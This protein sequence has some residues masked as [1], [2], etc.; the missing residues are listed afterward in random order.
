MVAQ[1]SVVSFENL[2]DEEN[3]FIP[4]DRFIQ[5]NPSNNNSR[6]IAS[7]E[8]SPGIEFICQQQSHPL[9]QAPSFF[10]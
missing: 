10:L 1:L 2:G 5:N 4:D 7:K 9:N 3:I 6:T 8:D